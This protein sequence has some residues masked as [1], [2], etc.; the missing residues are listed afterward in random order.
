MGLDWIRNN[1]YFSAYL[2]CGTDG[3]GSC[4]LSLLLLL[5]LGLRSIVLLFVCLGVCVF[6]LFLEYNEVGSSSMVCVL[7]LGSRLVNY[8]DNDDVKELFVR[9]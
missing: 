7:L 8:F 4:P 2:H 9:E 6:G 1:S 3:E 5:A